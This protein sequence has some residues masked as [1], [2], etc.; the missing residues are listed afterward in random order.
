MDFIKVLS[1]VDLAKK[2]K[3]EDIKD[4]LNLNRLKNIESKDFE[5]VQK[6]KLALAYLEDL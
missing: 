6:Y 4:N 5:R 2:V 3:I 1:V